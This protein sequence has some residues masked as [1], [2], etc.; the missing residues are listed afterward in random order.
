M[1]KQRTW[2]LIGMIAGAVI[3]VLVV[4]LRKLGA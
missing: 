2:D 4:L 1:K 3:L